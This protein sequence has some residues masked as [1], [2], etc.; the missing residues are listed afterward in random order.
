MSAG[1]E[2]PAPVLL[3]DG[4]VVPGELCAELAAALET[5]AAFLRG[6][7]PP[8]SCAQP[9]LSR[10][11]LAVLMT[12]RQAAVDH[13]RRQA[14]RANAVAYAPPVAVLTPPIAAAPS[15][16]EEY[17][18][19]QAAVFLGVSSA[20]VR[21]LALS[22]E[23]PGRKIDRN[24]WRFNPEDV[25]AW[26]DRPRRRTTDADHHRESGGATGAGAA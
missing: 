1:D 20:R 5:Y 23:L 8:V 4:L 26:R 6:T 13:R 10:A 7:P 17:T 21:Q 12:A 14:Q 18:T 22:G 11:A 25:R 24:V 2:R 9:Q 15:S 19:D 16:P 3:H